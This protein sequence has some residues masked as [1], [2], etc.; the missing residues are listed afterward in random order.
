MSHLSFDHVIHSQLHFFTKP[1][2]YLGK[3]LVKA[4]LQVIIYY[5]VHIPK[6]ACIKTSEELLSVTLCPNS[7]FPRALAVNRLTAP[8]SH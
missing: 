5:K 3:I 2:D 4:K 1:P 7:F 6:M 8:H